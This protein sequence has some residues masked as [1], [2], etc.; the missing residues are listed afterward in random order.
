[1]GF[2]ILSKRTWPGS[3]GT[4]WI[5][6]A[7]RCPSSPTRSAASGASASCTT[8]ASSWCHGDAVAVRHDLAI[9]P[10]PSGNQ[11]WLETPRTKR[12]NSEYCIYIHN[13]TY[14]YIHIIY[15]YISI[16]ISIYLSIYICL[17]III[18][19]YSIPPW[20]WLP[21]HHFHDFFASA[22]D[23]EW[24]AWHLLGHWW[25]NELQGDRF[26]G[27]VSLGFM[28]KR[29]FNGIKMGQISIIWLKQWENGGWMGFKW[30]LNGTVVGMGKTMP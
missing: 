23:S 7:H 19:I 24:E 9:H 26:N 16:Y 13:Y 30:D 3:F 4:S 8:N 29:W 18:Y 25:L 27:Q 12:D 22:F 21:H 6:W 20:S 10:I 17:I 2:C 11:T 5:P 15:I 14:I 1:M 28:G